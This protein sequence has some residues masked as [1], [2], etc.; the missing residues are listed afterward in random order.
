MNEHMMEFGEKL[1]ERLEP[2]SRS[3]FFFFFK[4]IQFLLTLRCLI[5]GFF[6][7]LYF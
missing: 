7:Y 4:C 6:F 2:G 1:D 3:N 5:Q